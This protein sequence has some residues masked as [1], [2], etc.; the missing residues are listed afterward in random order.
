VSSKS[1]SLHIELP[2][3]IIE[4]VEQLNVKS[5]IKKMPD[6]TYS[7]NKS[8]LDSLN[9]LEKKEQ[10]P[11]PIEE[12]PKSVLTDTYLPGYFKAHIG[13]FSDALLEAGYGMNYEGFDCVWYCRNELF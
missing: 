12:L 5:G 9:S 11:L 2:N 8:E 7:L 10:F 4:G 1:P 13:R 6:K 3:F